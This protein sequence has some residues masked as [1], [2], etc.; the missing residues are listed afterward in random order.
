MTDLSLAD[1]PAALAHGGRIGSDLQAQRVRSAWLFL[2][3]TFLVLALVAGW[4]LIRTIYFSFTNASLTDL[5]NAEFVG[6]ANYLSWITLKS[7]R[8]IYRG[9]LA[10]PA[11]WNAVWNTLKFTVLSVSIETALGLIV[12]LVLNAQ[13][14]GRGLVRAAILIPWAIPT[15]V[16][17]KMWAWMLNDQF[18]ILN[19]ML[20]GLG[21]IGEKIAWTASPDTAMIA[22]L[23]VDVWKT[24]PFMALLILAGLQ[25]V[26]GDIYEA[27][28][29]DGVHPVRVFWRVTLP[30]IRPAL[31]VAVIFRMLD[32]L[33]IFDLIYVLTPNNAQTKTMSVMARENLF[34][35]DKFA[36]GAAASTMLF[37]IIATITILYMWIGRLNLS[38]GER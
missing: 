20:L 37:L 1:R 12:A 4:P 2:A 30:L 7:G 19:D 24:T 22:V 32:A 23:I 31:M 6:F 3:P 38:G 18:G 35:F 10:D 13:F 17:A 15:I 28:K 34:D 16:S 27:A 8:T 11:W 26:P 36:Y 9:L 5:S 29:I 25:M 33:R 21:L 14:P